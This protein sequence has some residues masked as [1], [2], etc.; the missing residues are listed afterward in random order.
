MT[1]K[2]RIQQLI[3]IYR[4]AESAKNIEGFDAPFRPGQPWVMVAYYANGHETSVESYN[5]YCDAAE[6]LRKVLLIP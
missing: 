6:R 5:Y 3:K 4:K 1:N 2:A